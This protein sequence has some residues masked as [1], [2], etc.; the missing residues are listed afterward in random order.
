MEEKEPCPWCKG[1][2][3]CKNGFSAGRQRYLCRGCHKNF[4]VF[5]KGKSLE[6]QYLTRAFQLYLEGVGF[7]AIERILGIGHVT[8]MYWVRKYGLRVPP[9]R[10]PAQVRQVEMDELFHFIREKKD[11]SSSGWWCVESPSSFL[12]FRQATGPRIQ[13]RP[14]FMRYILAF[15]R[16][17]TPIFI[18]RMMRL[19]RPHFIEKARL[20]PLPWKAKIARFVTIWLA[21]I[22]KPSVILS[23]SPW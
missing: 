9:K 21:F 16:Q 2:N 20:E 1:T 7:R 23:L 11:E 6:S 22:G 8:V 5:K 3:Y 10:P 4:S 17:S 14:S 18:Q 12:L 15:Q 13:A 19:F